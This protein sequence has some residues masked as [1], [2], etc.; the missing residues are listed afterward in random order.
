M[1]L[2]ERTGSNSL[3]GACT[4]T[5]I[6]AGRWYVY[7]HTSPPWL[8]IDRLRSGRDIRLSTATMRALNSRRPQPTSTRFCC[9]LAPRSFLCLLLLLF[10]VDG[11]GARS[12][13]ARNEEAQL[14]PGAK[15]S[16]VES[17]PVS[18]LTSKTETENSAELSHVLQTRNDA[19]ENEKIEIQKPGSL[20][21]KVPKSSTGDQPQA[22]G[23]D[24][25]E[26]LADQSPGRNVS[27]LVRDLEAEKA[28]TIEKEATGIETSEI[29][30]Q[31][32]ED[33]AVAK[34][35][36]R[37][38][39]ALKP[40]V[41]QNPGVTVAK[42]LEVQDEHRTPIRRFDDQVDADGAVR[43]PDNVSDVG[44]NDAGAGPLVDP[45]RT[46][47]DWIGSFPKEEGE[48]SGEELIA[49]SDVLELEQL[50]EPLPSFFRKSGAIDPDQEKENVDD[51]D[52]NK[53]RGHR[54]LD[55]SQGK[56]RRKSST[57]YLNAEE[58]KISGGEQQSIVDGQIKKLISIR[59]DALDAQKVDNLDEA[60]VLTSKRQ[61]G[62]DEAA[63]T[64]ENVRL[65]Q[66]NKGNKPKSG[67]AQNLHHQIRLIAPESVVYNILQ[68]AL[69]SYPADQTLVSYVDPKNETLKELLTTNQLDILLMGEKLLP[70]TLRQ[71]Y[72]DRMFSCLR[73]FEY[74]SCVKYFAW[75]MIKQY[76]PA[77]PAFPDYQSWYPVFDFYPHYPIYPFPPLSGEVGELPEVVDADATRS[78]RP[79]P[80]AII[81]QVLQNTMKEQP[82]LSVTP[83]F[84]DQA[85]DSYVALIPQDQL[86]SINMAEQLIPV[87]Y[88]PQ[89]VR[90]TVQCMKVYNYLTCIKYSTWPAIRQFN[91]TLPDIFGILP[92]FQIPG[93]PNI[94]DYIPSLPSIP[95]VP[96]LGS[97]WPF[98]GSPEQPEAPTI[99]LLKN[100]SDT[101]KSSRELE[102]KIF[103]VLLNVSNSIDKISEIIPSRL[104]EAV[105]WVTGC[106]KS[107]ADIVLL[108]DYMIPE[109][110]S[111]IKVQIDTQTCRHEGK[112]FIECAR[113][114]I[115]PSLARYYNNLPEF[116]SLE[117]K[118]SFRPAQ[119]EPKEPAAIPGEKMQERVIPEGEGLKVIANRFQDE[120]SRNK[121]QQNAP[122]ISV[123]G[124]RFVP[125]FT[126]HPEN[127][128]LNI[129]RSVQLQ[130]Q[131]LNRGTAAPTSTTKNQQ[132]IDLI[133]EQQL[134]IVNIVDSLLPESIRTEFSTKLIS[135]LRANNFLVCTRDV[136][137]PTLSSYFPWLPSFPNFGSISNS[138]SNATSPGE[139]TKQ[140]LTEP[141]SNTN[142]PPLSETD[143]KTGQHGD[144]KVTITDTRFVPIF[145]EVPE[146]VILNILKAVQLS[147]PN[148]PASPT[149]TRSK[150][151]PKFLTEQQSNILNIAETLL[152]YSARESN[153]QRVE[154]CLRDKVFLQCVRDVTW[155]TIAQIYPWLPSFPNF[156]GSQNMPRIRLHVFL[157]ENSQESN[158]EAP[159][160][161]ENLKADSL[162]LEQAEERIENILLNSLSRDPKLERAYLDISNPSLSHLTRRQQNIVKLVELGIPDAAR[163]TY[164]TRIQECTKGYNFVSC[165]QNIS[166]PTLKQFLPMLPDFSEISGLLPQLP[167]IPP[168]P[169]DP[170]PAPDLPVQT[171][172]GLSE[173]P[174]RL[175]GIAELPL[176]PQVPGQFLQA[177]SE[178]QLLQNQGSSAFTPSVGNKGPVPEYA[179]Q[180]PGIFVDI[181]KDRVQLADI[182][183]AAKES[184][185]KRRERRSVVDLTKTYYETDETA[186]SSDSSSLYPN[187]T[188]SEYL[189][190]LIKMRERTSLDGTATS[191]PRSYYAD[192]LNVTVRKSLTADQYEIIKV[193]EDVDPVQGR[194]IAQQV[195]NCIAGLSF[196]RCVGIFMWPL[197]VSQFPL[198]GFFGRS[199]DTENQVQEIFGMSTTDFEKEMLERKDTIEQCLLDWYKKIVEDKF[200]TNLGFLTIKG[201]GNGEL[202]ISFSG[203]RE[204][205][206]AKLKDNKNLPSILTIISDIMEEVLDQRPE[207]EKPKREKEKKEKSIDVSRQGE[208]QFLKDSEEYVDIMRSMN[209]DEIITM[210]LDK[211][212]TNDSDAE[213]G[214]KLFGLEDA[215]NAFEV[216]FGPRL[217][218][219]LEH[220]LQ[221]VNHK[222]RNVE[223]P[224]QEGSKGV[225]ILPLEPKKSLEELKVLPLGSEVTSSL[226]PEHAREQEQRHRQ[227]RAK[228]FFKSLLDKHS[229]KHLKDVIK[230][231][232]EEIE[233]NKI[234]DDRQDKDTKSGLMVKLPKLDEEFLPKKMTNSVIHL[235]RAV[236]DKMMQMMPG[237][238]LIF[239]FLLQMAV[240]HARAA[241]SMAGMISNMAMGSAIVGMIR[242]SFFGANSH[243]QIKYVYDNHKI[244]PGIAWPADYASGSHYRGH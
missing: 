210:F 132:F 94:A 112:D 173:L 68:D 118:E 135:C 193:V 78:R 125:I 229:I 160:S 195:V 76:F 117:N 236:K 189:R 198:L 207:G 137:W 71:E 126:E 83:S 219:R 124:T 98:G 221:S 65:E 37:N 70:Q 202:G 96:D 136:I 147:L 14:D 104:R 158:V 140:N 18:S 148:L 154:S 167:D 47:K 201:Y 1:D 228:N 107:Q 23:K 55:D 38:D 11:G 99:A 164:I 52:E 69:E 149:P 170:L 74:F 45:E 5:G 111:K 240:A 200:Q 48:S 27:P 82:R 242:D 214:G 205:R 62:L 113:T 3:S 190:L 84:I 85:A 66:G 122:V 100:Q 10:V 26:Q 191:E 17:D 28:E 182:V 172:P 79:R 44:I 34:K 63:I 238:S 156:G 58:K 81:I 131:N 67:R 25:A 110:E 176:I 77:L 142:A 138:P 133:N 162:A 150:D 194:G 21:G 24:N 134:N 152:P 13:V 192:T 130:S 101:L 49:T 56:S 163:A 177:S 19:V 86:L 109:E 73:R 116:P 57:V 59:D 239:S 204:G 6:F 54:Y 180:P 169:L 61:A 103:N 183:Q 87:A 41:R 120:D 33:A 203:F 40:E 95:S 93:W 108:S 185:I 43:D 226:V 30:R 225:D 92:D 7:Y 196:I 29:L 42:I 237:L 143:V 209:D 159:A 165:T 123:T 222:L 213:D 224:S 179:G 51:E 145:N 139:G 89:F 16:T 9:C 129:V 235:G 181:S 208:I 35:R 244:G 2:S 216:L 223:E 20:Q 88:R 80:E 161:Q 12:L 155:P 119:P 46:Q 127:V 212:R 32:D 197:I 234:P 91:P 188:E 114:V 174:T 175:P 15:L 218:S 233:N 105:I 230:Q 102:A 243:P 227:R 184:E 4:L 60:K 199:M 141:S 64:Q 75:P 153:A 97:Y 168:T 166:W 206:G 186:D 50:A 151:F 115:W 232:F 36:R 146:S 121:V 53:N 231:K 8:T 90:N 215:Y 211:I 72:S 187:M 31:E 39:V 241:A 220:K 217:H 128:I 171:I 22:L 157:S 178:A 144:T 106:T